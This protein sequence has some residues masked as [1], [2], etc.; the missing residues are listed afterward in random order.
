[1]KQKKKKH[2]L[3]RILVI[4]LVL[5]LLAAA[6]FIGIPL[7]E[8]V[9]VKTADR[10]ADWMADLDDSLGLNEIV[11]PGTHDAAT[12]YVQLAF[13]SK[14][15]ALSIGEQLEAGFR[16]LDIRL[17]LDDNGIK[18]MH[19]FTSCKTGPMPW[20]GTLCLDAV[21]EQCY[22]FLKAHPTETV[23]FAVKKEHGDETAQAFAEKLE[24][25]IAKNAGYWY[26]GK[27]LPS[28][29]EVRGKLVLLRR[30]LDSSLPS[31]A[32]CAGV[33]FYWKDQKGR[34]DPSKHIESYECGEWKLWVQDRFEY[35]K[36]DK[37][38]AFR[39]G[40]KEE[41]IAPEDLSVHFLSTK[42]TLIY[43]HPYL[44]AKPLNARLLELPQDALRGWIIVDFADA[45]IAQHIWSA[46]FQ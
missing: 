25:E 19:G 1:M 11:L 30:Y 15:Q 10:S 12:Q 39:N 8:T 29:G 27:A 6:A 2:I 36:E 40:L 26:T 42:G 34:E 7:A 31:D 22:G 28:L 16:Y 44:F 3:R 43:G 41:N 17:G 45:Q 21:L 38:T 9:S 35:G 20:S 46:N 32:D 37:W 24:A 4:L 23:V 14:C 33:T 5:V 18:L 13:F